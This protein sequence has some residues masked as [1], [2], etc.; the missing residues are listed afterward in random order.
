MTENTARSAH[1][2]LPGGA[3]S[4]GGAG[5]NGPRGTDGRPRPDGP[6]ETDEPL[7][8]DGRRETGGRRDA[9]GRSP[10]RAAGG[11]VAARWPAP[12]AVLAAAL[13]VSDLGDARELAFL[14]LFLPVLYLAIAVLD[15]A[16]A[17]WLL[18][19][20]LLG[21]HLLLGLLGVEPW[22]PL[23]GAGLVLV[24]FGLVRG[25]LRR[26]GL[27]AL[28]TPALFVFGGAALVTLHVSPEAGARVVALG[29]IAHAAWDA[30]HWWRDRVVSRSL[31][32]WCIVFDVLVGA[33]ILVLV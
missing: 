11:W 20:G 9:G 7:K 1:E 17:S 31:A 16:R 26:P 33:G 10:W 22:I 25:Q 27:F 3:A 30:V 5:R 6:H 2:E 23:L 32:E 24:A 4:A 21:A 12:T 19:F 18:L 13:V 29:L 8:T 15:R 28:Q 14:L